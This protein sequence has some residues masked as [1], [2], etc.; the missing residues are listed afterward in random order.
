MPRIAWLFGALWIASAALAASPADQKEQSL[1]A[2]RAAI[3]KHIA[4][5]PCGQVPKERAEFKVL[6]QDNGFVAALQ[7][8]RSSGAPGF[9]AALM[10]A[11]TRAQP[12][13]LPADA[14]ARRELQNLNLKFDADTTPLP[15]CK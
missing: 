15:P 12:Y 1:K 8:V 10:T 2:M 6:L 14:G 9:D 5:L 3:V 4:T 7:L 13:R 11:I